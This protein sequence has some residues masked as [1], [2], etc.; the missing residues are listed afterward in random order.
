MKS[1]SDR[2]L[3]S[4]DTLQSQKKTRDCLRMN[5]DLMFGPSVKP[6]ESAWDGL[7]WTWDGL[8]WTW[9]GDVEPRKVSLDT[10]QFHAIGAKWYPIAHQ[11]P[12]ASQSAKSDS[13]E[14]SA[15]RFGR[16]RPNHR[17]L[18]QRRYRLQKIFTG[19]KIYTGIKIPVIMLPFP[20]FMNT[21]GRMLGRIRPNPR[22]NPIRNPSDILVC[23][24]SRYCHQNTKKWYFCH[25][26]MTLDRIS[27]RNWCE[28]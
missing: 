2:S 26:S 15:E 6:R 14:D 25:C 11:P 17:K 20:L 18:N 1:T 8:A 10:Y 5:F 28:C 21:L 7:V 22:P 19:G 12:P 9:R 3:P 24:L 23:S 16:I 4:I 27:S 13:A